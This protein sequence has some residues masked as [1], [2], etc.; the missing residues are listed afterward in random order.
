MTASNTC[1]VVTSLSQYETSLKACIF[2][3]K[4]KSEQKSE[5]VIMQDVMI[6]MDSKFSIALRSQPLDRSSGFCGLKNRSPALT[7]MPSSGQS[8]NISID[9]FLLLSLASDLRINSPPLSSRCLQITEESL[10]VFRLV[11]MSLE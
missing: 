5:L 6:E 2:P 4:N 3:A 8:G 1:R 11:L 10:P 7:P 9:N